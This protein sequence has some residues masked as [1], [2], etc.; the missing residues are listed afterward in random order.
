[1]KKATYQSVLLFLLVF[2]EPAQNGGGIYVPDGE[3]KVAAIHN[4]D[5]Y[6]IVLVRPEDSP[7]IAGLHLPEVHAFKG[8]YLALWPRRVFKDGKVIQYLKG[9]FPLNGE[10]VL[11]TLWRKDEALLSHGVSRPANAFQRIRSRLFPCT[12]GGPLRET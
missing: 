11:P 8:L 4:S 1:M 2:T 6:D 5:D 12:H 7:E 3:F 9:V 10:E